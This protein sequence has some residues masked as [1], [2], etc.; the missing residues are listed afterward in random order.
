VGGAQRVRVLP[1]EN[2]GSS[3]DDYFAD[4]SPKSGREMERR[5]SGFGDADVEDERTEPGRL[6]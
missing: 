1:F 4:G 3:D 6:L 5:S 2:L